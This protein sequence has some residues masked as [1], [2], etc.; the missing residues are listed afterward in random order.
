M[1]CQSYNEFFQV[2]ANPTNQKII[3]ALQTRSQNV[4]EIIKSTGIEQSKASHALKRMFECKIVEVTRD[5]KQRVYSLNKETIIP[6][7]EM[8]DRHAIKM[9]KSCPKIKNRNS[10]Y[11]NHNLLLNKKIENKSE[12]E[13]KKYSI[14]KIKN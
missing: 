6:I 10:E 4:S 1:F 13:I 7:L 9:C 12:K 14:I 11:T 8:V 5:G 2:L 3:S